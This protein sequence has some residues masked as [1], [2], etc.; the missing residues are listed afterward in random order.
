MVSWDES[1]EG[2]DRSFARLCAGVIPAVLTSLGP[3][4]GRRLLDAGT[5]T[6]E[7]AASGQR[8]GF[9][10]IGVDTS[11]HMLE[12][13]RRTHPGIRFERGDLTALTLADDSVDV[14]T[15]S[16]VIN[17]T[18]DPRQSLRELSRVLVTGGMAAVT[19]WPYRVSPLNLLW[20]RVIDESGAV[21]PPLERLPPHLDFDR[22][23]DG[24]AQLMTEEGFGDATAH[25]VQ[26]RFEIEADDLWA[27]AEA[28]I[29]VIGAT[30]LAQDR[31]TQNRMAATFSELASASAR[32]GVLEFES[33]AILATGHALKRLTRSRGRVTPV[34][35]PR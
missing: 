4:A 17:H 20:R 28:G 23:C 19:I 24:L 33:T 15:A 29:A 31:A 13:A 18:P 12:I 25:E 35:R 34:A 6:G 27:G 1:A 14:A 2:Y 10:V 16:F 11:G 26:W 8:A 30:Y 5:G 7:L 32:R 21:Q 3:A 9:D 22:T